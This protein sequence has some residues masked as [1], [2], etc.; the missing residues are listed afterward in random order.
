MGFAGDA[1]R[2]SFFET[3]NGKVVLAVGAAVVVIGG[4]IGLAL[5]LS[6]GDSGGSSGSSN[7]AGLLKG[8]WACQPAGAGGKTTGG[9]SLG[10][11]VGDGTWSAGS[12]RG[13]WTQS[14]TTAIL[15]DAGDS[16]N[17]VKATGM[18]AGAGA[19]AITL[20]TTDGSG[21]VQVHVKGDLA[22]DKL[23]VTVTDKEEGISPSPARSSAAKAA[24]S[25]YRSSVPEEA[26]ENLCPHRRFPGPFL[27]GVGRTHRPQP[28]VRAQPAQRLRL[29]ARRA[30]VRPTAA[31]SAR[32]RGR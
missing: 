5:G 30:V 1:G 21:L 25:R 15:H 11:T 23:S 29:P 27:L 19:F 26:P 31:R 8:T 2:P 12:A 6:G 22:P 9:G 10:F 4:G 16:Q 17:D 32:C 13:T 20:G 28:D 14:G 7:L 3:G 24:A 18:P